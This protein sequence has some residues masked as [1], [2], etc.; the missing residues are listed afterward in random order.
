MF[1]LTHIKPEKKP[2]YITEGNWQQLYNQLWEENKLK[3][4]LLTWYK[5]FLLLYLVIKLL[6]R[7][8]FIRY[9]YVNS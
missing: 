4:K 5:T 3:W 2:E 1:Q 7:E 8:S 6:Q 9:D